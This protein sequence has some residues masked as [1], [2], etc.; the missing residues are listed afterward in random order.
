M[1]RLLSV[2]LLLGVAAQVQAARHAVL[3]SESQMVLSGTS[4][5][6]S[7]ASTATVLTVEM[8][9]SDDLQTWQDVFKSADQNMILKVP[10]QKLQSGKS[11]L[12]KKMQ[13]SL[14][15]DEFPEIIFNLNSYQAAPSG[16]DRFALKAQGTLQVA[17]QTRPIIL[18]LQ[19]ELEQQR[20]TVRGQTK[21]KMS[22]FEIDPPKM[23]LGTLKTADQVQLDYTIV[24]ELN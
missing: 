19:A 2:I 9:V 3:L 24:L 6:H 13:D 21:L 5:L 8:P 17:G 11:L 10:V 22:T 14:K 16:Q 1:K 20:L 15:A 23:F 4:T 12:D 18:E 7:Y